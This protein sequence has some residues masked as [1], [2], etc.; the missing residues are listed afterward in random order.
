M[1]NRRPGQGETV[2]ILIVK[3][4]AIGDVIH[5]LPS[6]AALRRL[7]PEAD[8]TWV[9]EE[10]AAD[11]LQDHPALNRV[12]VSGR[13]RWL[14][15]L[16]QGMIAKPFREMRAFLAELRSRKYDLVIDFHGLFKSAVIVFLSGGKRKLGYD[17]FQEGSRLFYNEKITEALEKH[18]VERYLDFVRYLARGDEKT[19]LSGTPEFRI[20]IGENEKRKVSELLSKKI[21]GL[22][23][24]RPGN[25]GNRMSAKPQTVGTIDKN[26]TLQQAH[27]PFIAINPV[28]F[29]ETKLWEDEKFARLG[30]RIWQE[31]GITVVLTGG[32]A[33]PL[34]KIMKL[35]KTKALNLGGK[36]SL[37]ELAALYKRAKIVVTTDS[38][39]M[40]LAAAVGTPTV[41][42]FGPTDPVRTG[43]YGP[44]HRVIRTGINC[45]PCFRKKCPQPRCM[46]EISVEEVFNAVRKKLGETG[47][48]QTTAK[49]AGIE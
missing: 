46:T 19:C 38:G 24:L 6:L 27:P 40:H 30:D 3:L 25:S 15:E 34:E 21:F 28:A 39:P 9:V 36:T 13:K 5:T 18:A 32:D 42:L 49:S 43:P 2:N 10:A 26:S 48:L 8:I 47:T 1:D 11:L 7:W 29:W 44:G 35:M 31:L 12:I 20:T 4:S 17:S 23:P 14:K 22:S 16:R 37:R 41:A 45:S 33:E